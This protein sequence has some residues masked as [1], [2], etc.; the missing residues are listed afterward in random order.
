[1]TRTSLLLGVAALALAPAA[2]WADAHG[3]ERGSSGHL[4]IIYWQA[5]STLNPY[6]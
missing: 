3:S 6:L 1:M 4:N 5:P 2:V